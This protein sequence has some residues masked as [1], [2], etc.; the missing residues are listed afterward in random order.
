MYIVSPGVQM[1]SCSH[2]EARIRRL[3]TYGMDRPTNSLLH[4][5]GTQATVSC[6]AWSPDSKLLAS[7]SLDKMVHLWDGSTYQQ[8]ATLQGH[9]DSVNC[10]AW[11][12]NGKLLA[13]GSEDETVRLWDGSTYQQLVTLEWNGR[14]TYQQLVTLE[15]NRSKINCVAW[16]PD[17]KLLAS[18]SRIR[19]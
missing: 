11:S 1:A 19:R 10:V 2:Q 12:A 4:C 7:G 15:W 16:S 8:L 6:V 13:S 3:C 5:R 9:T 14:S 18:G 17:S